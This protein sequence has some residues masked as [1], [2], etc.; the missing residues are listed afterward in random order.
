MSDNATT[1]DKAVENT[2]THIPR[3]GTW[4]QIDPMPIKDQHNHPPDGVS[5]DDHV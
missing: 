2:D 3:Q 4:K 5:D 1:V